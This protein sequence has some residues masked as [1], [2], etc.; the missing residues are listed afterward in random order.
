MEFKENTFIYVYDP[1][2]GWCFGFSQVLKEIKIQFEEKLH[3]TVLSGGMLLG[4]RETTGKA[5][6]NLVGDGF[7]RVEEL[8][9]VKFG[10]AYLN[11]LLNSDTVFNSLQGS[12][13]L[14][15]FKQDYPDKAIEFATAIQEAIHAYGNEPS[16]PATFCKIAANFGLEENLFKQ[17]MEDYQTN[18]ATQNEFNFVGQLQVT[19]FPAAF[20]FRNKQ[21]YQVARGFTTT[22]KL[23][24]TIKA[25]LSESS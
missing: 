15:A 7:K 13:A 3:F 23:S 6:K 11:G 22:D 14:T 24:V 10:E 12:L 8:A 5:I 1:L 25:V 4:S 20:I 21:F 2:C 18:L 19:G 16:N 17:K 9:G